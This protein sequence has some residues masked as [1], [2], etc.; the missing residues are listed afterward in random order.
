MLKHKRIYFQFFGIGDQDI[1]L[2]ECCYQK[3]VDIHHIDNKGMGGSKEKDYI[4]NLM[5][6]CRRCHNAAHDE[7]ISMEKLQEIHLN[8]IKNHKP[9]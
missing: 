4:E 6:L 5:A 1:V 8:H 3:A 7:E 9:W 2:C